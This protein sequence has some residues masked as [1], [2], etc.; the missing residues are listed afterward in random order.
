MRIEKKWRRFRVA[1]GRGLL[2]AAVTAVFSGC[3]MQLMDP[4]GAIGVDERR[5][6]LIALGVMLLVVVPVIVLTL[7]FAWRYRASNKRAV[8]AP[9]WAH[10]T[11]IEV[12]VWTIPCLIVIALAA[13]IWQSTHR[14]DPYR[15][16]DS[17]VAPIRVQVVALNWKW[18]FIYP[19]F[20]VATV[21]RLV[22]PVG[23]PIA[24]DITADSLMNSFFIPRLGSQVYAMPAMQTQ[25]HL[26]A[27]SAGTYQGISA[28][29]SGPGFSD[30]HFAVDAVPRGNFND[31]IA[32][33]R[34][35]PAKLDASTYALLATPTIKAP[36]V[37]YGHVDGPVFERVVSR[38]MAMPN[39]DAR[40]G[41]HATHMAAHGAMAADGQMIMP[42]SS[43]PIVA[44]PT[45][46][47]G[48]N[49]MQTH[50]TT[51]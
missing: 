12:V 2:T 35:S 36:V 32:A 10:S 28:A 46:A 45:I 31:W 22:I 23:T 43:V 26:I 1:R 16:L 27:D 30:M 39:V 7:Y 6:I 13:L 21:N 8:Y 4:R 34:G 20:G 33:T 11:R 14:L 17:K 25:L 37:S 18:L 24:F 3:S 44:A 41:D 40:S 38:Y 42:A 9:T 19:D 29:Y 5:L 48:R 49:A 51:E 15:P 47:D 50:T